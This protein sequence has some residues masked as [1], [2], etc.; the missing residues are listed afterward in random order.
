[1]ISWAFRAFSSESLLAL[2]RGRYRLASRK[3]VKPEV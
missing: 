3:R 1:M 2:V